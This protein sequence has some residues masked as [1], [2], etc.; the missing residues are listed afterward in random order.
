MCVPAEGRPFQAARRKR[1]QQ[2][3]LAGRHDVSDVG[4]RK[5]VTRARVIEGLQADQHAG[6][7]VPQVKCELLTLE[8]R[9]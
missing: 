9:V 7:R 6:A 1:R 3:D 2:L 4:V 5:G 8:H